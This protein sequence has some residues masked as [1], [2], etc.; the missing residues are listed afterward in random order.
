MRDIVE[1]SPCSFGV[2]NCNVVIHRHSSAYY[3]TLCTS[4]EHS[5]TRGRDNIRIKGQESCNFGT[6]LLL[7][8]F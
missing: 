6:D 3:I 4:I 8:L 5:C 2:N 7:R 1:F